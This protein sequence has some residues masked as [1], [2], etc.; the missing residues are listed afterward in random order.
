MPGL[1]KMGVTTAAE[2][3][4]RVASLYTTGVPTPFEL[5]LAGRTWDPSRVEEV[6][7]QVSQHMRSNPS[8][9]VSTVE[10]Q[11]V[12]PLLELLSEDVNTPTG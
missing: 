8:R 11:T 9:E 1:V 6:L 5:K 4:T 2:P 7:H 12:L 10:P 3:E